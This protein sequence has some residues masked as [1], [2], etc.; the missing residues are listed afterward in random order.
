VKFQESYNGAVEQVLIVVESLREELHDKFNE[1]GLKSPVVLMKSQELNDILNSY[2][3]L[4]QKKDF[5]M[6]CALS[7]AL[8][9]Q[10]INSNIME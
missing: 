1:Y 6:R 10:C 5:P 2:H 7:I 4:H 9:K 8:D 3:S